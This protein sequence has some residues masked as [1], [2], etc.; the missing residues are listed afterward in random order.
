[1]KLNR[2][3][4]MRVVGISAGFSRESLGSEVKPAGRNTDAAVG[5]GFEQES[6]ATAANPAGPYTYAAVAGGFEIINGRGYYNRPIWGPHCRDLTEPER[7]TVMAGDLPTVLLHPNTTRFKL[8]NLFLGIKG[9]RWFHEFETIKPRY[10]EGRQD[11]ELADP[12]VSR[13]IRLAFVRPVDFSGLLIRVDLPAKH[14]ADLVVACGGAMVLNPPRDYLTS[15][16]QMFDPVECAGNTVELAANVFR[17]RLKSGYS[18]HDTSRGWF[19][20]DDTRIRHDP[21][22]ALQVTAGVPM[23]TV[24]ADAARFARG[25][26]ALRASRGTELPMAAALC[27]APRDGTVYLVL[28]TDDLALPEVRKCVNDLA[29][30]FDSAVRHYRGLSRTVEIHTPDPYL[31]ATLAAQVLALDASWHA[32]SMMH[33][34][35][36]WHTPYAGWRGCYGVTVSGWHDRVQSHAAQ[37]FKVQREAPEYPP[38]RAEHP[39]FGEGPVCRGAIPGH[40]YSPSL[41]YNMGEVLLDMMFYDWLWTGDLDY[42]SRAFDFIAAK[43]LWQDRALDPDDDG[44]YENWLNAWNTDEKWHNGG[45]CAIATVYTWRANLMM[46]DIAKRLG[47]DYCVFEARAR[48]IKA[49]CEA[50]LWV[51]EKGVYAEYQDLQGLKRRH[52]APDQSSVYTPVDLHFCDDF[53]AYQMLRFTEYSF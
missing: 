7:L 2:R 44:L 4:F 40:L 38:P 52:E 53:Q 8:G 29:T 10:V 32:P 31:D 16:P 43:L 46:A 50:L 49:A 9:G 25:P 21:D 13:P 17:I 24:V 23:Q 45:G 14:R 39:K 42:M 27:A 22:W 18:G 6:R 41:F 47:K 36:T 28:T 15:P 1:M 48:K 37:F 5:G 3:S 19:L 34:A 35:L 11:Y 20:Y 12:C 33:G 51:P 30:A 26:A